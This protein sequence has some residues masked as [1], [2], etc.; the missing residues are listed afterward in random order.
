MRGFH[1]FLLAVM[2]GLL[3]ACGP[4]AAEQF[5][6]PDQEVARLQELLGVQCER[7]GRDYY[8]CRSEAGFVHVYLGR[9]LSG[10]SSLAVRSVMLD[11]KSSRDLQADTAA[12][13]GFSF[14]DVTAVRSGELT[15]IRKGNFEM[16]VE[17]QWGE[18]NIRYIGA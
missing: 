7:S 10:A 5:Q 6:S 18:V 13:Y 15:S 1:A 9:P 16:G 8:F 14:D 12:L 3:A 4:Q 11:A 17:P 2:T